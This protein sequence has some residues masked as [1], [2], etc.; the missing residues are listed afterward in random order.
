MGVRENLN[1]AK[2]Y[3]LERKL[4][5]ESGRP[6]RKP[7]II[8]QIY[9]Q[10][11]QPCQFRQNNKCSICGCYVKPEGSVFN[12]IA[13]GT[14]KCP[15]DPPYWEEAKEDE[16]YR[17]EGDELEELVKND[18]EEKV[19][20]DQNQNKEKEKDDPAPPPKPRRRCCR[21]K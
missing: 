20:Q 1:L 16:I 15:H 12:K 13:W 5:I 19:G 14:T 7:A 2:K 11:C 6:L 21:G 10:H 18:E 3:L 17:P 4:W 8:K 9:E